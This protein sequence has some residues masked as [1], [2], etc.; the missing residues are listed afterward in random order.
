MHVQILVPGVCV[1]A[2]SYQVIS[3][4]SFEIFLQKWRIFLAPSQMAT[5]L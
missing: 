1:L 2:G 4:T 5:T 3:S